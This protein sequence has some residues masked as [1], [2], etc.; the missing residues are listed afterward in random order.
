MSH[1]ENIWSYTR[2]WK[3]MLNAAHER[4]GAFLIPLRI[5]D[6]DLQSMTCSRRFHF[7]FARHINQLTDTTYHSLLIRQHYACFFSTSNAK[8]LSA[9]QQFA[10]GW[11]QGAYFVPPNCHMSQLRDT[12]NNWIISCN[13]SFSFHSWHSSTWYIPCQLASGNH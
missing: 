8:S 3:F 5:N 11:I 2:L 12:T 13:I 6:R 4:A 10:S 7:P 9:W 1:E